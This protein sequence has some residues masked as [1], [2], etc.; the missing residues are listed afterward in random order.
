MGTTVSITAF[1]ES[2]SHCTHAINCAFEEINTIDDLMSL[3]KH[4]SQLSK[5]NHYAGKAEISVDQRLLEVLKAA[6]RFREQTNGAF[7]VTIE[8]LMKLWGFRGRNLLSRP[9]DREIAETREAVGHD[10]IVLEEKLSSVGLLHS[11][12]KIDLGGIAVG[13]SVDRAVKILE[14]QGI[15]NALINHSGDIYAMGSPPEETGW[16]I[17]IADPQSPEEILTRVRL[18]N[19]AVSTSGN[20][21]NHIVVNGMTY[22]HLMDPWT[23]KPSAK[24]LSATIIADAAI[25]ADALSTGIFVLGLPEG[26]KVIESLRNVDLIA[27]DYH[28]GEEEIFSTLR[29]LHGTEKLF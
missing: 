21:E 10:N 15:E 17:G 19:K 20:Y 24:I 6:E 14:Q 25:Q 3:Y 13:Y 2:T 18:T 5:I 27:V 28:D 16:E 4:E 8:P 11:K 1:G 23:G 29:D 26:R 9:T 7:D 22:G 12:S